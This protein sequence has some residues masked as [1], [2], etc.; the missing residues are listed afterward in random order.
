MTSS[1]LASEWRRARET[2]YEAAP[3]TIP[4]AGFIKGGWHVVDPAVPFVP[5]WHI[6]AIAEHLEAVARGQIQRLVISIAPGMA[7]SIGVSVMWPAWIWTWNPHFSSIYGSHDKDLALRDSVR[8]RML[9]ESDWYQNEF[10]PSWEFASDQNV[11]GYYRNTKMG[12]RISIPVGGGTGHRVDA[13]VVDDPVNVA[14]RY[15]ATKMEAAIDWWEKSMSSRFKNPKIPR[16]V[17]IAQR[18]VINDL[19]G[20]VLEAGGYEHLCLPS[21]FDPKR[22]AVTSL[23]IVDPRKKEGELLF[24]ARFPQSVLDQAKKDLGSIDYSAQHQQ[25]PVPMTGGIFQRE[26]FTQNFYTKLPPAFQEMLISWDMSFKDTK[27]SDYVVGDVW[28]RT[29]ADCYLVYERRGQMSFP[30]TRVAVRNLAK[31][32]PLATL[33]LIEDKAN[34][35]AIIDDLK[36]EVPG[37]VAV[38]PEGSKEARAHSVSAMAEAGNVHLPHP[39]IWP[40]VEE[41]LNEVCTFPKG[42]KDDRVDTFT[43]A[44]IRFKKH[45]ANMAGRD[46]TPVTTDRTEAANVALDRY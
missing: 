29:G 31:A 42:V 16:R 26:W 1:A 45:I 30:A 18:T 44:M 37:L 33:K 41:W 32:Y 9:M 38:G 19:T 46:T 20:H 14:D 36:A 13:V 6:D 4:L 17:V 23:G 3:S 24:P 2:H 11:K 40:E 27:S 22:R 43:Q 39:E 8:S 10:A 25:S 15:S 34:G 21:E 12:E 28:G 35:P 5:N 7:K